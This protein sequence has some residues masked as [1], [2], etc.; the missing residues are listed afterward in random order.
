[1]SSGAKETVWLRRLL[2][3]LGVVPGLKT[4][5][6]MFVENQAAMS[7]AHTNAVTRR[8]KHIDVRF[9]YIRE[10]ISDRTLELSIVQPKKWW[11]IC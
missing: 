10:A 9:H 8:N 6:I 3:G 4:P 1:M 5:T 2:S 11:P 7:L